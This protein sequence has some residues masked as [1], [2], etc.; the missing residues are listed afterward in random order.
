MRL[1]EC[2]NSD[3]FNSKIFLRM[4]ERTIQSLTNPFVRWTSQTNRGLI[5][6]DVEFSEK[7]VF[8]PYAPVGAQDVTSFR[9][10]LKQ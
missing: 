6:D 10:R 1:V 7:V 4:D 3:A 9:K 8:I 5:I 2:G